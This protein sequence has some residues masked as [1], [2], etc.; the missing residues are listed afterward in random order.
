M[1][2]KKVVYEPEVY[3]NTY[4]PLFVHSVNEYIY[5]VFCYVKE[6]RACE[7]I[8]ETEYE[9]TNLLGLIY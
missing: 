8:K 5:I 3:T 6:V 9:P 1:L 4:S 2:L 7:R